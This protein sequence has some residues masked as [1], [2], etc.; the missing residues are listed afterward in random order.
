M[1]RW[2][3]GGVGAK[4]RPTPATTKHARRGGFL[5]SPSPDVSSEAIDR[6]LPVRGLANDDDYGDDKCDA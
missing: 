2:L 3:V 5:L 4:P 1:R 6:V